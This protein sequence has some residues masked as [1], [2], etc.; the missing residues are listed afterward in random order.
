MWNVMPG[1]RADFAKF[2]SFR[3]G[4]KL[5][6]HWGPGK[7]TTAIRWKACSKANTSIFEE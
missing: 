3:E 7:V 6:A 4:W 2:S 5:L 1:Y